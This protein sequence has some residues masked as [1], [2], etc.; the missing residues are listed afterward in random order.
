MVRRDRQAQATIDAWI[1][2]GLAEDVP[3]A[4]KQGGV[5]VTAEARSVLNRAPAVEAA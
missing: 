4:G 1:A 3:T 2:A 5:R